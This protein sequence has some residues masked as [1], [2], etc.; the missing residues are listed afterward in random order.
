HG[1]EFRSLEAED[2]VF[3][4]DLARALALLAAPKRAGRRQRAARRVIRAIERANGAAPLQVVEG[5]YGPYVTDGEIN[6]SVPRG[7]DPATLSLEDAEAL[8][9]ARRGA[10]PVRRGRAAPPV[11]KRGQRRTTAR[12]VDAEGTRE[13]VGATAGADRP[14]RGGRSKRAR[15]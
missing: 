8:L 15:S 7:I 14:H 6:A 12:H 2:D 4:V 5:R 10:A 11:K 1:D 9:E 13:L 3:T